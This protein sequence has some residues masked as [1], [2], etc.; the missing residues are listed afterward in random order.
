MGGMRSS[1]AVGSIGEISPAGDVTG[2]VAALLPTPWDKGSG[3]IWVRGISEIPGTPTL[4]HG[5]LCPVPVED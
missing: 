3:S 5:A 4:T 1:D 2:R